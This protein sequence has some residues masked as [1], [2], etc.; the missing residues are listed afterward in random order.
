MSRKIL[1]IEFENVNNGNIVNI[2]KLGHFAVSCR[3][4]ISKKCHINDLE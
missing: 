3:L 2:I 4:P 1:I